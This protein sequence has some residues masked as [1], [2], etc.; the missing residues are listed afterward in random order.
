MALDANDGAVV[1]CRTVGGRVDS[2]PTIYRG[3][4]LFGSADGWVYCLRASD[5]EL[6]WRFR[7]SPDDRRIV[8]HEQVESVWP[9]HGSVLLHDGT[10]Y[11]AAGRGSYVD[12]GVYVYRLNAVTG[13]KLSMMRLDSRDPQTGRQ[14]STAIKWIRGFDMPGMLPDILSCQGGTIYMRHTGFNP[15][16]TVQAAITPHL[17][18][19]AGYLDDTYWHRTYWLYGAEKG[20][21]AVG[22]TNG[23]RQYPA[24][25]ILVSDGKQVYGYGRDNYSVH[26]SH[27][28]QG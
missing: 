1:W 11:F 22:W 14:P 7:A 3:L 18:S 24:G 17:Y 23:G 6:V 27:P 9:V 21:G 25:E 10:T 4:A 13:E 16:G 5:G 26:G 12:G 8:A 19:P 28:A 20:S 2:P 15:D